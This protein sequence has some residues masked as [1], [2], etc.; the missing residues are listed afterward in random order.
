MAG[1]GEDVQAIAAEILLGSDTAIMPPSPTINHYLTT[2]C[3]STCTF[4]LDRSIASS[5]TGS[6]PPWQ[7]AAEKAAAEHAAAAAATAAAAAASHQVM[8]EAE[9]DAVDRAEGQR[10]LQEKLQQEMADLR[11]SALQMVYGRYLLVSFHV[12]LRLF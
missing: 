4:A 12:D 9:L 8:D 10:K 2:V 5:P 11:G 3:A 7:I 6:K 1:W